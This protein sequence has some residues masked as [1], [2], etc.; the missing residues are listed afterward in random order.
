M[1]EKDYIEFLQRVATRDGEQGRAALNE[2]LQIADVQKRDVSADEREALADKGKAM[3]DGSYPIANENDL[4]NAIQAYGRAK[5]K[6]GV[7]RHIKRRAK[8]L[9][10][11][12]LIPDAWKKKKSGAKKSKKSDVK[13]NAKVIKELKR[14]K[15]ED[16]SRAEAIDNIIAT[17]K[18]AKKD[19]GATFSPPESVQNA[20]KRALEWIADDK[21][22][23]G[24]TG[25]GRK[26]ASDLA[27]G[28]GVSYKTIKRIKAYFDRHQSDKDA[29]GFNSGEEGFPSP[30]RVAWDAWGGDAAWSW[31]KGIVSS[32]EKVQ[33]S[34]EARDERGRW[35]SGG[36]S[37][38]GNALP[39]GVRITSKG[40][41]RPVDSGNSF[42]RQAFHEVMAEKHRLSAKTAMS[43]KEKTDHN[44]AAAQ[45]D[46][47]AKILAQ[48]NDI[49]GGAD[50]ADAASQAL[51]YSASKVAIDTS[52]KLG[53]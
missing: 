52:R 28:A 42:H 37:G 1:N 41:I 48:L 14:M 8:E 45:H 3:P 49:P 29:T 44:T 25:V 15:K 39:E 31:A 2:L 53:M 23:G 18:K 17:V 26:R 51:A 43:N 36:G 5:D 40:N 35:T 30:G 6:P 20:A 7:K 27:R 24:F 4:K 16:P 50:N 12:D 38:G 21:A 13:K 32:Q 34:E 47:A 33:K 22:G 46:R 10:R 11:T 9:G 19:S